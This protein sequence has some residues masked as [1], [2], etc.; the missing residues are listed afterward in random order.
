MVYDYLELELEDYREHL[1]GMV[2]QRTSQLQAAVRRIE[3]TYDET[4]VALAAAVDLR[5]DETAGHSRRVTLY[6]LEVAKA[7]KCSRE[8]LKQL[9][10]GALLHDI[11]KI[12]IP[13]SILLKPGPLT[14]QETR[15]MRTHVYAGHTLVSRI[16]FL[17]S[18]ADIVLSH[19]ERFDGAG[20]P[21]GHMRDDIPLGARIFA[22]VDTLDAIMS[23]RPYRLGRPFPV[24]R[25]VIQ[26]ESGKQ[27]D[28]E[29]VK[30]FLSIK[31]ETWQRLCRQADIVHPQVQPVS[32]PT[33][34][35]ASD[36]SGPSM[37]EPDAHSGP[38][39]PEGCARS[40]MD[41]SLVK[42]P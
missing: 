3:R 25:K 28:P 16:D 9:A 19:H 29:V 33:P 26:E 1:E 4:L 5:N 8:L 22:V 37:G 32:S 36:F 42:A 21:R 34:C 20:Y 24:A 38:L 31:E 6:S 35:T 13:D 27:F 18:A 14:Q 12:A 41:C 2:E 11:G 7:M 39:P 17:N 10:R 15:I 30:A 40:G 23:D